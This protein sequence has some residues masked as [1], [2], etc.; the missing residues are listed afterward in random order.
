MADVSIIVPVYNTARYLDECV[1][2]IVNQTYNNLEII[3]VDDGSTDGISSKMCDDYASKDSRIVVVHKANG[4]LM[5]AWMA[6]V[7]KSTAKYLCFVDGDDW[8]DLDMV[9]K[10]YKKVSNSDEIKDIVSSSYIIEKA[11]ESKKMGH[12]AE[13]GV[14]EGALLSNLKGKLLGEE[15]R[16]VIMSRCM[17]LIDRRL[18]L[19]NLKYCNTSIRMAEDVNITLPAILDCDRLTILE[20]GYFYHYRTVSE[21]IAHKY[22][23]GLMANIDLCYQTFMRIFEEKHVLNGKLQMDREYVRMLFLELKNEL[24]GGWSG[25]TQRVQKVFKRIDIEERVYNTKIDVS[26]RANKLLYLCMKNPSSFNVAVTYFI[27]NMYDK[28]TN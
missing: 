7:E 17:K 9:E 24:R 11:G 28:K 21:S 1:K 16:P 19:D 18:I 5:S 8:V 14:Y 12:G 4:G 13:P 10:L 25:C 2:G 20:E 26:S 6:G 22:N 15:V 27:L 23:A 3:L